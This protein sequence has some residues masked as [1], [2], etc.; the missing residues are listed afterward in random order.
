[1]KFSIP[2]LAV[3][4]LLVPAGA[5]FSA[6]WVNV[7]TNTVGDRFFIDKSAIQRSEANV[8]FWEYREFPQPNNA[9]LEEPVDQA[10]HGVVLNWSAN[11]TSKTQRLRQITAYTQDRKII[12]KFSYGETGSLTQP[13]AGS[14][15]SAVLGYVCD[16]KP[17][18]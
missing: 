16:T 1:M 5:A 15:A 3:A 8:W 7:T 12:R 9:F 6:D 17:N 10:V 4:G 2:L 14:S 11:C 18:L 13:K